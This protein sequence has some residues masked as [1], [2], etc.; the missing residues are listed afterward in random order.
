VSADLA[1]F[2]R[3]RLDEDETG[4]HGCMNC[5]L[6][7]RDATTKTGWTHGDR[8]AVGGG[9]QG[10]RCP[11]KI[12]GA[13]PWPDPARVLREVE[14]KRAILDTYVNGLRQRESGDVAKAGQLL[15]L[16]LVLK[17]FAT[18]YSDHPDYRSEWKP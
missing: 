4:A 7:I 11:G 3:A 12:T 8:S 17:H 9:W 2:L 16:L 5:G 10:I 1:A 18:V 13:L 6:P 15:G 14:A